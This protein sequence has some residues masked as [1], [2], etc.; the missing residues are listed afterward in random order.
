MP[1]RD[2]EG[3]RAKPGLRLRESVGETRGCAFNPTS[4]QCDPCFE[5]R[6]CLKLRHVERQQRGFS[7]GDV[8]DSISLVCPKTM[9]LGTFMSERA[10]SRWQ[11]AGCKDA[12][13]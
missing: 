10:C 2:K 13:G 12:G 5:H 8:C 7:M 11:V 9:D 4:C 3:L 6:E 1:A